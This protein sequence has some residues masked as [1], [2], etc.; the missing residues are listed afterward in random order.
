M[1]YDRIESGDDVFCP[2]CEKVTYA[3][4][5]DVGYGVTEFWG[6][7]SCHVDMV[8]CCAV[9]GCEDVDVPNEEQM[10]AA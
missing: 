10:E 7:V 1:N 6:S 9:C 5:K 3:G 2:D 8:T 4:M